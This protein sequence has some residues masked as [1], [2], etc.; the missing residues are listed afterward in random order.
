MIPEKERD[1]LRNGAVRDFFCEIAPLL[2]LTRVRVGLTYF[3]FQYDGI[4]YRF[5]DISG[6]SPK[7]IGECLRDI[8]KTGECDYITMSKRVKE[9]SEYRKGRK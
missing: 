7:A 3:Q 6:I 2:G 5:G 9:R 8:I 1:M 4:L